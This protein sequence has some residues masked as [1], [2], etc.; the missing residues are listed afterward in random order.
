MTLH[1]GLRLTAWRF[2][3]RRLQERD[4]LQALNL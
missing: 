1:R 4:S 3:E 2:K